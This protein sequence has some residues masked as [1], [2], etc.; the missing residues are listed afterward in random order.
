MLEYRTAILEK[1]IRGQIESR[2]ENNNKPEGNVASRTG[3]EGEG[4]TF[5]SP[6]GMRLSPTATLSGGEADAF[7]LEGGPDVDGSDAERC[8]A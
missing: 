7:D 4:K 5:R 1:K 8:I 2:R 3:G 6:E